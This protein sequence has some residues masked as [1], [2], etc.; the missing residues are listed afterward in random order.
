MVPP[1][2]RPAADPSRSTAMADDTSR[3]SERTVL[4]ESEPVAFLNSILESSTE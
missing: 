1:S 3:S 2:E 4:H